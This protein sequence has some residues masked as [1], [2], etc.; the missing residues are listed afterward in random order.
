MTPAER[1]ALR[2]LAFEKSMN[3]T[4]N[5]D[6]YKYH[7]WCAV[8]KLLDWSENA[9]SDGYGEGYKDEESQ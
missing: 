2:E 5:D 8:T 3:I 1:K 9:W 4:H 6:C 7:G